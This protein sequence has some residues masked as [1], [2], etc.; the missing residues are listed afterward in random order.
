MFLASDDASILEE[1]AEAV[2]FVQQPYPAYDPYTKTAERKTE[3]ESPERKSKMKGIYVVTSG[4]Y[5]DY[6][7]EKIFSDPSKA[8]LYSLLDSDR[9]VEHY[10]MDDT[11]VSTKKSYLKIEYDYKYNRIVSITLC[12]RPFRSRIGGGWH[13]N[14]EVSLSMGNDRVYKNIMRYGKN[15][16][17]IFK[18]VQD[19]LAEYLYERGMTREELIQKLDEYHGVDSYGF[20]ST[21]TNFEPTPA[22]V[23]SEKVNDILHELIAEGNPPPTY[24]DVVAMFM[25]AQK[26]AE[27]NNE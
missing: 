12:A 10:V 16:K 22:Q 19:K 1:M 23:A 11:D 18:I 27:E 15:S 6:R 4:E 3:A 25:Q 5:S 26:D 9:R 7:I 21:S 13:R 14:F 17:V 2:P 24:G 20:Y 8:H